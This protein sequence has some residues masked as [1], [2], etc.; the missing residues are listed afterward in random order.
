MSRET[1]REQ[2][3]GKQRLRKLPIE[4]AV[5]KPSENTALR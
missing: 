4:T 1:K 3:K 2:E 5:K